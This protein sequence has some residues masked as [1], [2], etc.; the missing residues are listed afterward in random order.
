MTPTALKE[1][2]TEI[3]EFHR[4]YSEEYRRCT[5]CEAN[6]HCETLTLA[7]GVLDLLDQ[8]DKVRKALD[9]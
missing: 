4:L 8:S 7:L 6:W 2:A 1:L 5:N 3:I 9:N